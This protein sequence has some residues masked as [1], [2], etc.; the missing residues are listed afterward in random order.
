ML[1]LL[2][3]ISDLAFDLLF[4]FLLI[5]GPAVVLTVLMLINLEKHQNDEVSLKKERILKWTIL[6]ISTLI[7]LSSFLAVYLNIISILV[8]TLII[9][10]F[11]LLALENLFYNTPILVRFI[12][13]I[14][15]VATM[16]LVIEHF[17]LESL[18]T[19]CVVSMLFYLPIT[20]INIVN[21]N[22]IGKQ[23]KKSKKRTMPIGFVTKKQYTIFVMAIVVIGII[24][25]VV[26][27]KQLI[28]NV[29]VYFIIFVLIFIF[30]FL[31]LIYLQLIENNKPFIKFTSDL[32][33]SKLEET[34][35]KWIEDPIVNEEY[36]NYL[37]ML[38]ASKVLLFDQNKFEEMLEKIKVPTN[39]A[40]KPI[41]DG[42]K[43]NILLD[44]DE[45]TSAYI[46]L[47][48][49]YQ[50]NKGIITQ[51]AKFDEKMQAYYFGKTTKDINLICPY[52]TKN[53]EQ[54]A[55]NLFIQIY[56]YYHNQNFVKAKELKALFDSKYKGL[57]AI[58]NKLEKIDWKG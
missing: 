31:Y 18:A 34:V 35:N 13:M 45:Y 25:G 32:D 52:Q 15:M 1:K 56:Y 58:T 8:L 43:V 7:V 20:I 48:N 2:N 21:L 46:E 27:Y 14:M 3:P 39:K 38:L 42:L 29:F 4:I 17:N 23:G 26:A 30:Y 19:A 40:Y 10:S 24:L 37:L 54:N 28:K 36:R 44:Q 9:I 55:V 51:L 57:K 33:Y 16:F 12:I 49:K 11:V 22:K 41:Y 50:N 5:I 47:Q 6:S 53:E